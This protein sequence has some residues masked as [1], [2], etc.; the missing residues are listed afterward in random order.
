M[1]TVKLLSG[2]SWAGDTIVQDIY[3]RANMPDLGV[4]LRTLDSSNTVLG[5]TVFKTLTIPDLTKIV[6]MTRE[7]LHIQNN[8]MLKVS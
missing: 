3:M 8:E 6:K 2:E 4:F 1:I 7:D 5:I